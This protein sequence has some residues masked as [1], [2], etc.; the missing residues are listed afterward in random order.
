MLGL[1]EVIEP[2]IESIPALADVIRKRRE[3]ARE[4][5][6]EG[7]I[8][9]EEARKE[10]GYPEEIE[11]TLF[12]DPNKIPIDYVSDAFADNDPEWLTRSAQYR[13]IILWIS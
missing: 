1:K 12:I 5:F 4:D 3:S 10:G 6:K 9:I 13:E 2:N 11:G 7:I 8:T